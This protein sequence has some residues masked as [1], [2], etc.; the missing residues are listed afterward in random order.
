MGSI[1]LLTSISDPR[2]LMTFVAFLA[3]ILL[4]YRGIVDVEVITFFFCIDFFFVIEF[5]SS[6]MEK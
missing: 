3:A 6:L 2:N 5:R 1:P 4:A